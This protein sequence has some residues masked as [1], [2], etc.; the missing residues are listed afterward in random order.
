MERYKTADDYRLTQ[1][2]DLHKAV[3]GDTTVVIDQFV[4]QVLD[5]CDGRTFSDIYAVLNKERCVTKTLLEATLNVLVY[6]GLVNTD[7]P[8]SVKKKRK[9]SLHKHNTPLVS[10]VI[11]NFNGIR[12]LDE[13]MKSVT[14]QDYTNL[15]II[16]VD[17][18]STDGSIEFLCDSYPDVRIIPL[19]KNVGFARGNNVGIEAALGEFIFILN[20]DTVLDS[21]CISKLVTAAHSDIEA[22]A[23]AA[24]M[25]FYDNPR[26]V[27]SFGNSVSPYTWGADNFIG[28]L[29][30]GQFQCLQP[31]FSACFGAA[32][33]RKKAIDSVGLL[34][35][36][37]GFYYEDSD[38][39][40]RA[41]LKGWRVIAA[42]DAIVYHKFSASMKEKPEY[43]KLSFA[44]RNRLKFAIKNLEMRN[45]LWFTRNYVLRED[46]RNI[47]RYLLHADWRG[48][49]LY[50]RAYVGL[51][52]G[53]PRLLWLRL[54]A[55][56]TRI[57]SATDEMLFQVNESIEAPQL[58]GSYP[59][60]NLK[61]IRHYYM[62]TGIV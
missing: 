19:L 30:V 58:I 17:N 1:E 5:V 33:L 39:C 13:L 45:A 6:A 9:E 27:N 47:A 50:F 62:H 23:I 52:L 14:N 34:D 38:W 59:V 8:V 41:R 61:N 37:F 25:M 7:K 54:L 20:N 12:H 22:G 4:K 31:S 18:G 28:Y 32:L 56:R 42:P 24:R 48:A 10:I 55:Q 21:D 51:A 35:P 29:D 11:L 57:Q 3:A 26:F 53:M 15:E 60:I 2:S 40:Y 16:V 49:A 46:V 36:S 43:F 44:V